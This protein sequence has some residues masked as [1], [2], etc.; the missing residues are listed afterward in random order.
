MTHVEPMFDLCDFLL[1][2][3]LDGETRA[4]V[5]QVQE[6]VGEL[7]ELLEEIEERELSVT[8]EEASEQLE[9]LATFF[10]LHTMKIAHRTRTA[11]RLLDQDAFFVQL[12]HEQIEGASA[13]KIARLEVESGHQCRYCKR[14]MVVRTRE[15]DGEHFWSC[16][17]FPHCR[18]AFG[19]SREELAQLD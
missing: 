15:V 8:V 17:R 12:R 9:R 6:R 13:R 10:S 7:D 4:H 11:R 5:E 19:L 2:Q 14:R 18:H 1:E 16:E 3:E